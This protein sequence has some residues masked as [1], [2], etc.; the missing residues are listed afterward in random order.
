MLP[1][2]QIDD[3]TAM[4]IQSIEMVPIV[5]AGMVVGHTPKS[6]KLCDKGQAIER[7]MKH[8]GLFAKDNAQQPPP[9]VTG[10]VTITTSEQEREALLKIIRDGRQR[11]DGE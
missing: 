5:V 7:A 6:V 9:V 8:L 4:A 3:E 2:H 10:P 11:P 1:I